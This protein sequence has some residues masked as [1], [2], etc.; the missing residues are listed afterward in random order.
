LQNPEETKKYVRDTTLAGLAQLVLQLRGVIVVPFYAKMLGAE[1]YGSIAQIILVVGMVIPVAG[2]NLGGAV[3]RFLP[4]LAKRSL[5]E[6]RECFL[7][8]F[9]VVLV[10]CA[11]GS[12]AV[13]VA[14]DFVARTLL[15]NPS[16]G[17]LLAIGA[18]II[19]AS[20][21]G[22]VAGC[23]FRAFQRMKEY[24]AYSTADS[25]FE[26]ILIV[27]AV[28]AGFGVRGVVVAMLA[29]KSLFVIIRCAV[30]LS[31]LGLS[32]PRFRD[33]RTHLAFALPLLPK[34]Y[35][36]W[37]VNSGDRFVISMYLGGAEVGFYA[38]A[39]LLSTFI[40]LVRGAIGTVL[41][42]TVCR[43]WD[44][45]K[46]DE[47]RRYLEHTIV[48]FLRVAIPASV[49]ISVMA[50]P[51]LMLLATPEFVAPGGRCVPFIIAGYTIMGVGDIGG[52]VISLVKKTQ[53]L[54]L[55]M[56]IGAAINLLLNFALI[57]SY[58]ISGAAVA[59]LVAYA[60]MSVSQYVVSL[61]YLDC[62]IAWGPVLKVLIAAAAMGAIVHL[63]HP[64]GLGEILVAVA[65]GAGSY[66]L[67]LL[68]MGGVERQ[69]L[70]FLM[71]VA[72]GR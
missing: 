22:Y 42:P 2:L 45:G 20:E 46:H 65:L 29:N 23:Y 14:S 55:L 30:I 57:P 7:S 40:S 50:K 24:T 60:A 6:K 25:L 18:Y 56:G 47:T 38:V 63:Y 11:I 70:R 15:N 21:A 9:L 36:T 39:Y 8:L 3:V 69:E 71:D 54:T 48:Y 61:R 33:F 59:T 53:I 27:A 49:G 28:L 12:A 41:Y 62:R 58:G 1:G 66:I 17:P 72:R 37:A 44:E 5:E 35:F 4:E 26:T 19:L 68:V 52:I 32:I 51:L 16:Q 64:A 10:G 34:T 43:L 31:E 67:L 13:S